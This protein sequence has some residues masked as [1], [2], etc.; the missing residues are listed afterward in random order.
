MI[1]SK[2]LNMSKC[3]TLLKKSLL[4]KKISII[5]YIFSTVIS[6]YFIVFEHL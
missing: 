3:L 5:N 2:L 6:A 4:L 1:Q